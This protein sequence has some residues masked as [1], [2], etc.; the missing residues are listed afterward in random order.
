MTFVSG[1]LTHRVRD[2]FFLA[3]LGNSIVV[4]KFVSREAWLVNCDRINVRIC[5]RR[6]YVTICVY[7]GDVGWVLANL[8]R[9]IMY[10]VRDGE[11]GDVGV[12]VRYVIVK[13]HRS[14]YV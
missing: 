4:G 8:T 6:K 7:S 11:N 1:R 10:K 13:A 14:K 3:Y 12:K 2:I 9:I 5:T